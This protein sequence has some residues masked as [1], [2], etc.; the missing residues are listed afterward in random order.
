MEI[1]EFDTPFKVADD[2][3]LRGTRCKTKRHSGEHAYHHTLCVTITF[4][5]GEKRALPQ[6]DNNP[7]RDVHISGIDREPN[8][9]TGIR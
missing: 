8:L 7:R 5:G 4:Q 2:G 9:G 6:Y 3:L 1:N